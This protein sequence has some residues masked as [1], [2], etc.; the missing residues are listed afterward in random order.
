MNALRLLPYPAFVG[1][2]LTSLN[3][4]GKITRPKLLSFLKNHESGQGGAALWL[5]RRRGLN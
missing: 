2:V 4:L 3:N 5:A 1:L